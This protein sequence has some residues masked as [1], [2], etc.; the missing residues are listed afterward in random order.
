VRCDGAARRVL[1]KLHSPRGP[2]AYYI[3]REGHRIDDPQDGEWKPDHPELEPAYYPRVPLAKRP[4]RIRSIHF[5]QMLS[6]T[7]S[8]G[9][10]LDT[11][12]AA[13]SM[14]SFYNH[15][16]GL[17]FVDPNQTPVTLEHLRLCVEAGRAAGVTWAQPD[18]DTFMGIDQMANFNVV[19]I[20][21]RL[22]SGLQQVVHVEEVYSLD[23]FA[24]CAE[25]M[26]LYGVKY[27]VI[28]I[29]PNYNEAKA[30]ALEFKGRVFLC[31]SFGAVEDGMLQWGDQGTLSASDRRTDEEAR[32]R[33]TV[34]IDQPKCMQWA[35]SRFLKTE[36]LMPDPQ[37]LS[38]EVID[39]N[40]RHTAAVLPRAFT[41]FT[42][43]A[44]SIEKDEDGGTNPYKR[45]VRKI[46]IDPHH[47]YANMLCDIAMARH[48]GDAFF[49][50]DD[51][52]EAGEGDGSKSP[53]EVVAGG[54]P[55]PI[56]ALIEEVRTRRDVCAACQAYP[57]PVDGEIPPS[58]ICAIRKFITLS[59]QPR[60]EVFRPLD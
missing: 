29:N 26:T 45:F 30:V 19:W 25:L 17:P 15:K 32:D 7:M 18:S 46:G 21:K 31:N 10:I 38:Q 23:P 1:P 5:P 34:R 33:Y 40:V 24:R 52:G 44:I 54:L 13:T 57:R 35:M 43:T 50:F 9:Q 49:I 48:Y 16:L 4:L 22:P 41:H 39:K 27:C 51:A 11:Y 59:D 8:P 60:C 56:A 14:K 55:P 6:P 28:E 53:S 2:D 12:D 3:C 42:K 20:K 47:S 36:C 58:G 37:G